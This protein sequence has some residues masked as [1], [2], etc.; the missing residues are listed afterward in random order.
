MP[1]GISAGAATIG[2]AVIGAGAGIYSSSQ[3][4]KAQTQAAQTASSDELAAAEQ[5]NALAAQIYNANAA[6]L[7]PYSAMGLPAGGE[8]NALLG[9]ATPTGVGAHTT[10][11]PLPTVNPNGS[12][13][14]TSGGPPFTQA[15]IEAMTHDG[16]PHNS[17]N[18]QAANAAWYAAHPSGVSAGNAL[19]SVAAPAPSTPA[20]ASHPAPAT[21]SGTTGTPSPNNAMAG[22]QTFYNSPTYQFPLQQGLHAVNVGYAAK[23]ALESGAAMKALNNYA[24]GNAAQALG[25]YMDQLY[26]QE[27][28]GESASAALAGVG[29]NMVGQVS[30]NNN[31]A[32]SAAGNAALVAG[33][34][35]ANNWNAIGS[36]VGQVAGAVAGAMGSSYHPSNALAYSTPPIYSS[37]TGNYIYGAGTGWS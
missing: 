34:G 2:A 18:A 8:Y 27:A 33:Q 12:A 10:P 30:A 17:A 6:R 23:G 32:A 5:N 11:T 13:S 7:D 35:S 22:F 14:G 15:Q 26:R 37:P 31:N 24:A 21:T 20:S 25:T 1:I 19:A 9:I 4:S 28:L 29:Q 16:I 36:G 3:A